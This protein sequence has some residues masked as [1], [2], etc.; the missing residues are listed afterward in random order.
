MKGYFEK[1]SPPAWMNGCLLYLQEWKD[2]SALLHEKKGYLLFLH[3]WKDISSLLHEKKR[4]S[5][6]P[7]WMKGYLIFTAWKKSISPFPAWMKGYLIFTAW[8]KGYLL[9]LHEW[10]D[11]SSCLN[12]WV[13]FFLHKWMD[14]FFFSA[15]MKEYLL[16]FDWESHSTSSIGDKSRKYTISET[17]VSGFCDNYVCCFSI[18]IKWQAFSY[19]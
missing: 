1:I 8:K 3:E 6:F 12:K 2:I 14:I 9:F 16:S 13:S 18:K 7:A 19:L 11:I 10:K 5:P 4:I 17:N 15:R